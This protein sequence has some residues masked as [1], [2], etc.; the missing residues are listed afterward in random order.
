LTAGLQP[1]TILSFDT[2]QP[3]TFSEKD[4]DLLMHMTNAA[5]IL[6]LAER[7]S[8]LPTEAT[9][10]ALATAQTEAIALAKRAFDHNPEAFLNNL[11]K[12]KQ[13]GRQPR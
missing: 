9:L 4:R 13:A 5:L 10:K 12:S 6:K 3:S 8:R 1:V 2:W 7:R 11:A